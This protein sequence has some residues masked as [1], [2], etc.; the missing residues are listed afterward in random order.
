[1]EY[2]YTALALYK[3]GKE[4][5]EDSITAMMEAGGIDVDAGRVKSLVAALGSVDIEQALSSAAM[6]S[7][8]PVMGGAPSGETTAAAK[9]EEKEEEEEDVDEADMGLGSLFG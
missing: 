9:E 2:L 4:I 5:T 7:A 6:V 1:M 3:A 8:A